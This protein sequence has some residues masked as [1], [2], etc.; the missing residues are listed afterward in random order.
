MKHPLAPNLTTVL[1]VSIL[2]AA[3][4]WKHWAQVSQHTHSH[5]REPEKKCNEKGED[6]VFRDERSEEFAGRREAYL[7]LYRN[8]QLHLTCSHSGVLTHL[9]HI[10]QGPNNDYFLKYGSWA[11]K[12]LQ[13]HLITRSPHETWPQSALSLFL[14]VL[15]PEAAGVLQPWNIETWKTAA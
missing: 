6:S 10:H 5:T 13:M 11:K 7:T 4:K 14:S 2:I 9:Q 12:Y 15:E 1:L 3:I 8:N